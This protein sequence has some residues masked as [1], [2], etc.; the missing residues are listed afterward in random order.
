MYDASLVWM[1][2]RFDATL[3]DLLSGKW[4]LSS[5]S[6]EFADCK[7]YE[8]AASLTDPAPPPPATVSSSSE[9]DSVSAS[10]S[11]EGTPSVGVSEPIGDV[12][13]SNNP[14]CST[15]VDGVLSSITA[16]VFDNVLSP[17]DVVAILAQVFDAVAELERIG[18]AHRD[19]K[20]N[21]ILVRRCTLPTTKEE[22]SSGR[23]SPRQDDRPTRVDFWFN[24]GLPCAVRWLY[25][26][27]HSIFAAIIGPPEAS[28]IYPSTA[29]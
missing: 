18:V 22:Y 3:G 26:G 9:H 16:G 14:S 23:S 29:S 15:R 5:T 25:C 10:I 28:F 8:M 7:Q 24:S 20:L 17:E 4:Q 12:P 13:S 1:I 19:I 27:A 2:F 6:P 11:Q 21:N